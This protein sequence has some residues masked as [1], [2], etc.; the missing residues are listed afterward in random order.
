MSSSTRRRAGTALAVLDVALADVSAYECCRVLRERHGEALPIVLVSAHRREP[1]DEVAALL[2]GADD[3][4][5]K[6]VHPEVFS[7]RDPP[8]PDARGTRRPRP[9][10]R[11]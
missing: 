9:G 5:V 6:P 3:Y 8:A 4:I 7:A 2:L 11:R 10:T 1:A